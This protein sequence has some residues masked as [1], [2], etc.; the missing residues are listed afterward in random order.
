MQCPAMA[1]QVT[2]AK[3]RPEPTVPQAVRQESSHASPVPQAM[4]RLVPILPDSPEFPLRALPI[5]S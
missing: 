3:E 4:E 5:H 1:L 2:K